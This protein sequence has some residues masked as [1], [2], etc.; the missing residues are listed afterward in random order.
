[1][2]ALLDRKPTGRPPKIAG[3]VR[4]T[5]EALATPNERARSW[6]EPRREV[7]DV[8]VLH[9]PADAGRLHVYLADGSFVCV[10]VCPALTG[11][12]QG[13]I[14]A[15]MKA[16]WNDI[17]REA[18]KWARDLAKRHTPERAM[19]DVLAKAV[20]ESERVVA[21]P[22]KGEEHDTPALR[23]AARAVEAAD[24]ADA[25]KARDSGFRARDRSGAGDTLEG[26]ATPLPKRKTALAAAMQLYREEF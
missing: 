5:L 4:E 14:A 20:A 26:A 13:A 10:A 18:R 11:D 7:R 19:V 15:A 9:D 2:R 12:D 21:L 3:R 16:E 23:E 22:R 25:R 8:R 17:N 24:K 6:A 1:M